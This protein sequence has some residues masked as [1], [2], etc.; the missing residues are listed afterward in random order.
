MS[1][2]GTRG[3]PTTGDLESADG[4]AVAELAVRSQGGG[5][6]LRGL[7]EDWTSR[8]GLTIVVILGLLALLAPVIAPYDPLDLRGARLQGPS[9]HHLMGTDNL[10]RDLLSRLLFGARL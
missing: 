6:L 5:G 2:L 7:L 4:L 10:G 1:I 8:V 3:T 9:W